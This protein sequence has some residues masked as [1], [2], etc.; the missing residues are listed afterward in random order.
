MTYKGIAKGKIVELE[1]PLPYSEG[2]V[3]CFY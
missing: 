2:Q 3:I 1:K